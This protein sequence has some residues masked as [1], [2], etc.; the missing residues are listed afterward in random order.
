[1]GRANRSVEATRNGMPYGALFIRAL[2]RPAIAD[3]LAQMLG[4]TV[5]TVHDKNFVVQ[6]PYKSIGFQPEGE[7]VG[8]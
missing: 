5:R 4:I 2:Q 1:M 3:Q 6:T 7:Q 8:A